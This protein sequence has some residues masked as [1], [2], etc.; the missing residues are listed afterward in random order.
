[1]RTS[2]R[3]RST[4][5]TGASTVTPQAVRRSALPLREET[6]RFPCLAT[7]TPAPA[8]TSAAAVEMLKVPAPSPPVPQV[9]STT[10]PGGVRTGVARRRITVAAAAISAG[11]SPFIRSADEEGAHLR[12]RGLALEDGLEGGLDLVRREVLPIHQLLEEGLHGPSRPSRKFRSRVGP[13]GV[14]T[15]SG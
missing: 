9:S 14:R 10:R 3:Q 2:A 5:S 6:L 12:R 11:V 4:T 13:S 15:L 1:M 7:V 8:T